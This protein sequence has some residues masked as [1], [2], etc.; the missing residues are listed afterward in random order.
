M[1]S[2]PARRHQEPDEGDAEADA[3]VPR[4][5]AGNRQCAV[6]QVEDQDPGKA[7]QHEADH[8]RLEPNGIGG[9]DVAT[10]RAGVDV[11]RSGHESHCSGEA[12]PSTLA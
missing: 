12:V 2:A 1:R 5:H 6:A 3:Q 7:E 4:A 10:G 11:V 8:D 9:V